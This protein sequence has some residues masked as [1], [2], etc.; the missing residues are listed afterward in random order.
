MTSKKNG[1]TEPENKDSQ[2]DVENNES[3]SD[4]ATEKT[5]FK[6]EKPSE[7]SPE[8]NQTDRHVEVKPDK[9]VSGEQ[10][11]PV[12]FEEKQGKRGVKLGTLAIVI[13]ILFAGGTALVFNQ[14]KTVH[15]SQLAQLEAKINDLSSQLEQRLS[16]TE[17]IA[18][19]KADEAY[20]KA[21][22]AITQQ[23]ES[24]KSLQVALA[25]VAG[26]RPNDWL[27]AESDYL[28]KLAGR[29][30]FLEKDV[31]SATQ[32]MESAD[33]RISL[34][35]DPSLV[36]L[37]KEMAKDITTLKSVPLID[38][39]GLALRLISLQE[40]VDSLP[41]ANAI[42]PE[43]PE[44]EHKAVSSDIYD[45][46]DNLLTSLQSFSEQFIT[47]RTREGNVIPLL[48]PKQHYYLKENV[49][50]KIETAIRAIY[51]ENQSIYQSALKTADEWAMQFFKLDDP[52]VIQFNKSMQQ[53]AGQNVEVKYPVKLVSQKALQDVINERLRR[54][55]TSMT[56]EEK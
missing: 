42:L 51:N 46:Q 25:D 37:R 36:P 23:H 33:Q 20:N 53:L 6:S 12:K 43:A 32:L 3:Q 9:G 18:A 29:K 35:N 54:Q 31:V 13:S 30:L 41:L 24:I 49:K 10:P 44:V 27:L 39:D 55:M 14:Q 2:M 26:R 48:A 16:S 56:S 50:G 15:E 40:Q 45:W 4:K 34:L 7:P 1:Q 5:D 52:A 21:E 47:F 28:V 11:A 17:S 19:A 22:T 8:E 38:K